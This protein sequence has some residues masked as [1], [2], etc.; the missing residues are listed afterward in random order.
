LP[1]KRSERDPSVPKQSLLRSISKNTVNRILKDAGYDPGP[2]RDKGTWDELLKQ[3][4]ASRWQC[5]FFSK[6]IVTTK[7]IREVFFLAF[8]TV[9]TRRVVLSPATF[10]P[11][12]AWVV[13]QS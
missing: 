6:R 5:D 10:H 2:K 4:A 9:E 1:V 11:D 8:L 12:E 3:H 7:G 13:E